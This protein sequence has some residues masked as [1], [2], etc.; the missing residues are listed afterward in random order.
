MF[1]SLSA[2][3]DPSVDY[4]PAVRAYADAV[5]R[6]AAVAAPVRLTI[7][8]RVAAAFASVV[9]LPGDLAHVHGVVWLR[10]ARQVRRPFNWPLIG[11]ALALG[12][13]ARP[14]HALRF[15]LAKIGA[16]LTFERRADRSR[17]RRIDPQAWPSLGAPPAGALVIVPGYAT[18]SFAGPLTPRAEQRL[19]AAAAD[20]FA[21]RA[22]AILVTGGNVHPTGTPFNEAF[23]MRRFL[24][25]QLSVPAERVIVEP[26]ARHTTTNLRNA[27]RLMRRHGILRAIVVSDA[28]PFGQT[29]VFQAPFCPGFGVLGRAWNKHGIA[30]G[31]LHRIDDARTAYVPSDDVWLTREGDEEP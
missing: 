23:E 18:P 30:L 5:A 21:G 19:R 10:I 2:V 16:A 31:R 26:L 7:A 6:V 3:A 14:F 28:A 29:V 8:P 12:V 24:V 4:N 25:D 20:F 27:G 11:F 13:C 1:S 9:C 15:C 22:S 17:W